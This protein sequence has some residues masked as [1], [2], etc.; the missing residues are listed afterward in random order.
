MKRVL[1]I[2]LIGIMILAGCGKPAE[3]S[4]KTVSV[5][6]H[7]VEM[8]AEEIDENAA[9][10]ASTVSGDI[11]ETITKIENDSTEE[12][13][14]E[15]T[16]QIVE[17][18]QPDIA[19]DEDVL[20]YDYY[21]ESLPEKD[22]E[23]YEILYNAFLN[24]ETEAILPADVDGKTISYVINSLLYAHPEFAYIDGDSIEFWKYKLDGEVKNTC[25]KISYPEGYTVDEL[26]EMREN[27]CSLEKT[28]IVQNV[29]SSDDYTKALSIY[30]YICNNLTYDLSTADMDF[31]NI[32]YAVTTNHAVC[33]GYAGMMVYMLHSV[34]IPAFYV[35]GMGITPSGE[36]SHAW[37]CAKLDGEW[38]FFDPTWGD[39]TEED[40]GYS[41]I[42]YSYF[43]ATTEDID[44]T[45]VADA[46][47]I[48]D[49]P[50]C[51]SVEDNYFY[52]S[53]LVVSNDDDIENLLN[54]SNIPGIILFKCTS[55]E[56]CPTLEDKMGEDDCVI[57]NTLN[58]KL[59]RS[60]TCGYSF[61]YATETV[62]IAVE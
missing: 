20:K 51:T 42:D 14:I 54:T 4:E 33:D 56:M 36:E 58:E 41:Y 9:N 31:R 1:L 47:I 30:D 32:Y 60:Y 11:L 19:F 29:L 21:Y 34:D 57:Y 26:K 44:T 12:T 46:N 2:S 16:E 35:Y 13:S 8:D 10:T 55:E 40:N 25:I 24:I 53:G 62:M 15:D 27:I 49:V 59:M 23:Y 50:W 43:A 52:R 39:K 48:V 22:K 28:A 18:T 45:H 6:Y 7:P 5:P 61:N 37:V 38:Y 17:I 3:V